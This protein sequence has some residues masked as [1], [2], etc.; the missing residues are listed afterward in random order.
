MW[1]RA[2]VSRCGVFVFFCFFLFFFVYCR[3]HYILYCHTKS[4][5]QTRNCQ[6][7]SGYAVG[8]SGRFVVPTE[9]TRKA[10]VRLSYVV[11][12]A[13]SLLEALSRCA[14]LVLAQRVQCRARRRQKELCIFH[15]KQFQWICHLLQFS[16]SLHLLRKWLL[17]R[18]VR[19]RPLM[20]DQCLR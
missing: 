19:W 14:Q 13:G 3:R 4:E 12:A 11:R 1:R 2:V 18:L 20:L 16:L 5:A 10:T 8:T 9:L 7:T 6:D 15:H 17:Y